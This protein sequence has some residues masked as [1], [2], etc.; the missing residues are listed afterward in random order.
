MSVLLDTNILT[1][2]AQPAHPM[3]KDALDETVQLLRNA[4]EDFTMFLPFTYHMRYA[5]CWKRWDHSPSDTG[6]NFEN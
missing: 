5:S 4:N 2:S 1:R 6:R 3:H